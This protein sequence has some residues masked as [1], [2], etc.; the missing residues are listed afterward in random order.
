MK[1][2]ILLAAMLAPENCDSLDHWK[3]YLG[4]TEGKQ[5]AQVTP[6]NDQLKISWEYW[7]NLGNGEYTILAATSQDTRCFITDGFNWQMGIK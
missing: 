6:I 2:L 5:L 3:Q 7:I 1:S 4:E